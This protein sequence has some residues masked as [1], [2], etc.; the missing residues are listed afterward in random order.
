M[1]NY[2]M[3]NILLIAFSLVRWSKWPEA[4]YPTSSVSPASSHQTRARMSAGSLT[5]VTPWRSITVSVPTSR[6]SLT[7]VKGRMM[8]NCRG[9]G[10]SHWG[11]TGSPITWRKARN[12]GDLSA[13]PPLT[14]MTAVCFRVDLSSTRSTGVRPSWL[15]YISLFV[16]LYYSYCLDFTAVLK[17][18]RHDLCRCVFDAL[19]FLFMGF[20][21]LLP[22][23]FIEFN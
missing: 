19:L 6:W 13:A 21:F 23:G 20:L 3:S 9:L 5:S 15:L 22:E 17:T 7:A 8:S 10:S 18:W 1:S 4:T 16:C 2:V 14:V 11:T 12:W